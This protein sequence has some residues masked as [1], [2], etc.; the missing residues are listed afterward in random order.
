[1][2]K[3][4]T[5]RTFCCTSSHEGQEVTR[6]RTGAEAMKPAKKRK[7]QS[8]LDYVVDRPMSEVQ[9]NLAN[10]K[11]LKLFIHANIS[12]NTANNIFLSNFTNELQPSFKPASQ[13]IMTQ[14][15]L[16]L[17]YSHVHLE[18]VDAVLEYKGFTL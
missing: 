2:S 4:Y 14:T 12:F 18:M 3:W 5:S 8:D 17:E 6:S 13:F 9:Q 15:F 16:D 1:M 11:L 7:H 10:Q